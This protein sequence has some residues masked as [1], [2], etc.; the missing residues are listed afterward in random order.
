[1]PFEFEKLALPEVILVKPKVFGDERGFFLESYK[2]KDFAAAGIPTAFTQDNHSKSAKNVI[3]GLHY[4][5]DPHAQG[6][7]V[8]VTTGKI[9]D[10]AV[11]IRIDS[12]T[13]G[14]WVGA[15][16]SEE[17][18]HMLWVPAGFAH[19]LVVLEDDTHLLYKCVGDYSPEHE[20]S[21]I[22]ND[23]EINID[24]P[25]PDGFE[26]NLVSKDAAGSFL[27]EAENNFRYEPRV[28]SC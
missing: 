26:P 28:E 1:M 11:D 24:W 17:N 18:K 2:A 19:G 20:R 14:K 9:F 22:W 10:V 4:Q 15:E 25:V 8:R 5:L 23:P 3:R 7:L 21:I 13:Y 12:P 6:K 16:L 27:K